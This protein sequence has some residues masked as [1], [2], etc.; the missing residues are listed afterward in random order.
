MFV[1]IHLDIHR[2]FRIQ[3]NS[4]EL[5]GLDFTNLNRTG[6][7]QQNSTIV[8]ALDQIDDPMGLQ[9]FLFSS[10]LWR[11]NFCILYTYNLKF[12]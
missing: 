8:A 5:E 12:H 3:E 10:K 2:L 7:N 1:R 9:W 4:S 11:F 6:L